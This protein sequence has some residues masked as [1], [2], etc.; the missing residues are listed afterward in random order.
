MFGWL[1]GRKNG[2]DEI[3]EQ[4]KTSFEGVKKDMNNLGEWIRH[5]NS[6]DEKQKSELSEIKEDLST[7]KMQMQE[8]QD[9][10]SF[11][12]N[13][14]PKQ[15]FRKKLPV[16]QTAVYEQ[17]AVQG[18][19][20]GVQTAVQ[21]EKIKELLE[22]LTANERLILW[23]LL[24]TDMRL[25]YEDIAA[26]LG[27]TKNTIRGQINSIK[28]KSEGL[29]EEVVEPSGKK[30]LFIPGYI[31]EKIVKNEKVKESRKRAKN[32]ESES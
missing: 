31:R 18:V 6:Q 12:K 27:K 22:N 14:M 9:F 20:T 25:S 28:K 30:R 26:M 23:S 10:V 4:T 5:L 1:F 3:K 11:W 29:I 24:N 13:N 17:T 8:M 7:I 2:V 15:A 32:S 16:V 21:T 19:Q